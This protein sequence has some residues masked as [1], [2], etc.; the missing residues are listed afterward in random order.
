[1]YGMGVVPCHARTGRVAVDNDMAS[2]RVASRRW[3]AQ[4][5]ARRGFL[6]SRSFAAREEEA[7]FS[8]ATRARTRELSFPG[9]GTG[10]R[11]GVNHPCRGARA[12]ASGGRL[13]GDDDGA[14]GRRAAAVWGGGGGGG[15]GLAVRA[16]QLPCRRGC[17]GLLC[18]CVC[19]DPT[20]TSLW[21]GRRRRALELGCCCC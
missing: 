20:E 19:A 8:S 10:A 6:A 7:V 11:A 2:R 16:G 5:P 9:Q 12:Q 13:V 15:G 14:G 17:R 18:L 21:T 3:S 4:H 1:M